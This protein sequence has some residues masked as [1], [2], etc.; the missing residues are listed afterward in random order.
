MNTANQIETYN[1]SAQQVSI[2][3]HQYWEHLI[4]LIQT[5][6]H[7]VTMPNNL[8]TWQPVIPSRRYCKPQ[9]KTLMLS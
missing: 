4:K 5:L 6:L 2:Y 1:Q 3:L 8:T 7:P 9:I